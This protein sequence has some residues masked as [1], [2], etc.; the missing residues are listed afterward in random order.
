M[1]KFN[2]GLSQILSKVF[3]SKNMQL[4]LT[5]Y[6]CYAPLLRG[7]VML[8]QNVTLNNTQEGKI[9]KPNKILIQGLAE[10]GPDDY[11]KLR[12]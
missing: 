11:F 4:E 3:L 12:I 1:V 7:T 6:C 8:T 9:Q 2:L 10:Q 5:K